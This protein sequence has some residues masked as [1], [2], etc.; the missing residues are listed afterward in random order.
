MLRTSV[1]EASNSWLPNTAAWTP[2]KFWMVM[3][4]RPAEAV[5]AL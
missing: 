1:G 5:R 3:S 2:M 4:A